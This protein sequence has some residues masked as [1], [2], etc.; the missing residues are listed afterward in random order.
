MITIHH[1]RRTKGVSGA[2]NTH[3]SSLLLLKSLKDQSGKDQAKISISP[4]LWLADLHKPIE[5]SRK[6][7]TCLN[8]CREN[9][10]ALILIYRIKYAS[11]P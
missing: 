10:F 2:L 3:S 7:T 8:A 6:I 5:F 1:S 11:I 4:I 9:H